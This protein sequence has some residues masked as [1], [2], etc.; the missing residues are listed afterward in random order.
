MLE[1]ILYGKQMATNTEVQKS[2]QIANAIE[3][4]EKFDED[5]LAQFDPKDTAMLIKFMHDHKDVFEM[6]LGEKR[7]QRQLN[8]L[9]H[10]RDKEMES[11]KFNSIKGD[12]DTRGQH[13]MDIQLQQGFQTNCGVK[14]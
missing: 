2:A 5:S 7:Y 6:H 10:I 4:I 8:I 13:L 14:G 11:G 12:M 1:N 3:F 9:N